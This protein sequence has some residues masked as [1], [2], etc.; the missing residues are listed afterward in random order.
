[1]CF[2]FW[3]VRFLSGV[4]QPLLRTVS[5]AVFFASVTQAEVWH[6]GVVM[7]AAFIIPLLL[8][9]ILYVIRR[10]R[11]RA[12]VGADVDGVA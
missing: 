10:L 4:D 2:V 11:A 5:G 9:F 12:T 6:F 8:A 3:L 7:S 1:M